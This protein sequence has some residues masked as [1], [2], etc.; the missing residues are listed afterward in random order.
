MME[1]KIDELLLFQR[2][3]QIM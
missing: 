1:Q 2:W 3:L